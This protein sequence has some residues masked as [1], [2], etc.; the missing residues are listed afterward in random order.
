MT[1]TNLNQLRKLFLIG[2]LVYFVSYIGRLNY[3]ASMIQ[4]G[5]SEGYGTAQLGTVV[6]ALFITYGIGQLISGILGDRYSP[7]C[8]VFI[9]LIGC[10][11][12]N[13]LVFLSTNYWQLVVA[14]LLNGFA[15]SLLWSPMLKLFSK[16]MPKDYLHKTCYNIQTSVALGTFFTYLVCS[17]MI[18]MFHWKLIFL[19]SAILIFVVAILWNTMVKQIE[20]FATKYGEDTQSKEEQQHTSNVSTQNNSSKALFVSSGLMVILIAVLIMGFLKDGIM[21]WVPGY[22]VDNFQ[23]NAYFS[24]FLSAFLPLVNL[25]GIYIVKYINAKN[26]NDDLRTTILFYFVSMISLILLVLFG[27]YS[28]YLS[29]F[30]FSI[31]TSCMLGINTILISLLPTYFAKYGKISTVSGITNSVTYLGSALCGYGLGTLAENYGWNITSMV[32]VAICALGIISC[33]IA[34]PRWRKF[35]AS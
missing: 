14:W 30:F 24:I 15:L 10:G 8:L 5:I 33:I 7:R 26:G 19:C 35:K 13:L 4:I 1:I 20:S 6:T 2:W 17:F 28:M 12:C 3:A 34:G 32:L 23:V 31:V 11:I 16:H 22:I 9:G 18:A 25:S 21:T 27:K 29:I